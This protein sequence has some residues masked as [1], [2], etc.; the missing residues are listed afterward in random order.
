MKKKI[1]LMNE[2]RDVEENTLKELADLPSVSK[3]DKKKRVAQ[4]RH[5]QGHPVLFPT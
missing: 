1:A 2:L 3:E 5:T 4:V